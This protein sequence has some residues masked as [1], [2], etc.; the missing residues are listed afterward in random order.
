M[1]EGK[2]TVC[3]TGGT[4][5][6][7]SWLIKNLLQ[8]GYCVRATVRCHSSPDD[9]GITTEKKKDLSYLRRLEGA[10]KRLKIFH[11]DLEELGSY[12]EAIEGCVGVFHLAHPM[13]VNGEEGEEKVTKRAM[14][15]TL[16]I[17]KACLRSKTVRRVVYASSAVTVLYNNGKNALETVDEETWSEIEVCQN[18][19]NIVSSSY[20]V[21]KILTEKAALEF[22]QNN[23][24]EVVSL[25]LP[26][27]VGPFICPNIPSSVHIALAIILGD[28]SKY[29]YLTNSYMVH[30]DDAANALI[31]LF[32]YAHA[33]GRY[34]CSSHQVSFYQVYQLLSQRY[35]HLH[36]SLPNKLRE[37][38]NGDLKFSDLSSRKLLDAGFK[39]KYGIN[40][41]YDGA[42]Q[43]CKEKGFL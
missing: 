21:S 15:G 32:E 29:E 7:A 37:T 1:E 22:G 10:S 43:C 33:N 38:A 13:D 18:G 24:L 3:V 28:H 35:P 11:G 40:E 14:E 16:G 25:V 19:N 30:I 34:I 27:V 9:E 20:L 39:F 42:I 8:R 41:M 12:D 6:V 5:F 4:G 26:L 2:G 23:G 36:I 17:L 31:F